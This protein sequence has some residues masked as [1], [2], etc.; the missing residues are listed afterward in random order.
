MA[1][2][3]TGEN[4]G[5]AEGVHVGSGRVDGR[6]NG[7]RADDAYARRDSGGELYFKWP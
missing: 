5:P 2:D 3:P 4:P 7:T 1:R 6:L